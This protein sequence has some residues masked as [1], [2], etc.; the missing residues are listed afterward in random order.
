[1]GE[2]RHRS[3]CWRQQPPSQDLQDGI[4]SLR[5]VSELNIAAIPSSAT[6]P[7]LG[8]LARD[9]LGLLLCG[10]CALLIVAYM[11]LLVGP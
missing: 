2:W 9:A 6:F 8:T 7:G 10:V 5:S 11:W 1:M 3:R 4:G